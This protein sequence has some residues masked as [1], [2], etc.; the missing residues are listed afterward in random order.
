MLLNIN[1]MDLFHAFAKLELPFMLYD[2]YRISV[3]EFDDRPMYEDFVFDT[4]DVDSIYQVII[5]RILT[6]PEELK[7]V[8]PDIQYIPGKTTLVEMFEVVHIADINFPREVEFCAAVC[9]VSHKMAGTSYKGL[10]ERIIPQ[11]VDE[12]QCDRLRAVRA[13][14]FDIEILKIYIDHVWNVDSLVPDKHRT[15]HYMV[16]ICDKLYGARYD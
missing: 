1:K 4:T 3:G 13:A 6:D 11:L 15:S 14:M 5:D 8:L 16:C 12:A 7:I 10:V 9:A 2:G